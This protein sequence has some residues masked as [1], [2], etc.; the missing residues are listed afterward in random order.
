MAFE[1]T[2]NTSSKCE[3]DIC[4]LTSSKLFTG[5]RQKHST[6]LLSELTISIFSFDSIGENVLTWPEYVQLAHKCV[7]ALNHGQ[8]FDRK[9]SGQTS[10]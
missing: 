3:L 1:A 6:R 9:D 10:C 7:F 2:W 5:L 8:H 4:I